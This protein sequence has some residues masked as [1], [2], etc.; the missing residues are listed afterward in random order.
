LRIVRDA[1]EVREDAKS[2][3]REQ[4]EAEVRDKD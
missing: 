2:L 1:M 4:K 3:L